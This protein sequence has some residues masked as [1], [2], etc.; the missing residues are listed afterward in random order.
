MHSSFFYGASP[1]TQQKKAAKRLRKVFF[2]A[3]CCTK[4]QTYFYKKE[5][6]R[7]SEM[8]RDYAAR[9][10]IMECVY[11]QNKLKKITCIIALLCAMFCT[12]IVY[13]GGYNITHP[14]KVSLFSRMS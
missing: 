13:R 9:R 8:D 4:N 3:F 10:T 11:K 5:L 14:M 1:E 2:A 6:A 12:A 7:V